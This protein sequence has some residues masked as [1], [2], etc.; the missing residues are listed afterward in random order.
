MLLT[1]KEAKKCRAIILKKMC[2]LHIRYR[3]I[4]SLLKDIDSAKDLRSLEREKLPLLAR[5]LRDTIIDVTSHRGGHLSSS[6]GVVELTIALHYA[7]NTP[8]DKLVWDVGHQSYAHKLL[9]GRR[10]SFSSLRQ[11]E[12][13]SGFPKRDESP[14]DCFG[15]GHAGTSISAAVGFTLARDIRGEDHN[16]IAVIGDG[17]M[18]SGLAFEGLNNAGTLREN[19]VVV[20]NDNEMSISENVGALS[21]YLNRILTDEWVNKKKKEVDLLLKSIPGIGDKVSSFAHRIEESIKVFLTRGRIFEDLGF[22]YVG[23]LDGHDLDTLIDTFQSIQKIK[24]PILVHVLTK[25]GKGYLPAEEQSHNFHG[26]SAFDRETGEFLAKRGG[27]TYTSA[28]GE[29]LTRLAATNR[30]ICAIT[31]AMPSGTG[32]I[33]FSLH[34]P[35]RFYDVG[36]AEEHAVTMAAA[37]AAEGLRPVVAIYST[38]LQR[39][40]DQIIHDVALQNLPVIFA[41][42][43]GGVVGQD[44]PT[45][46]GVFDLSFLRSVPNMVVGAPKDEQELQRFL[47]TAVD[48]TDAPFAFRYPRGEGAG[49]PLLDKIEALPI[50]SWEVLKE[51]GDGAVL[52]VG[53]MVLPALKAAEELAEEEG[54]DVQVINARFVKPMDEKMLHALFINSPALITIEENMLAGGFGAGVLEYMNSCEERYADAPFLLRLGIPDHFVEHGATPILKG[55]LGLDKASL[56]KKIAAFLK[57]EDVKK[58]ASSLKVRVPVSLSGLEET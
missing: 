54:L 51:G 9:T 42:D 21:N 3:G 18:S 47:K 5:E 19:M 31:A 39:A 26:V 15:T 33:D 43:R 32:L 30:D 38:F 41:L 48:Y 14:S 40:Y 56:K 46:H 49:L 17:S 22:K 44:G 29:T 35:D 7:F 25:K 20:L 57:E 55:K 45:H 58:R 24:K 53:S 50:G 52:A 37:M 11:F 16:V 1:E 6:L 8:E 13:I 12:G 10:T 4:M 2:F 23:P 36:I 28:F 27:L 34:Y